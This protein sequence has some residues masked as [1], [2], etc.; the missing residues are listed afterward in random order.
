MTAP[1]EISL[2]PQAGPQEEA[3]STDADIAFIGGSVF[4]GKTWTL[5]FEATRHVDAP[6]FTFAI[7]RRTLPEITNPGGMWDE[8]V[9]MFPLF[10][11][12]SREHPPEFEFPSGAWGR[13]AGLEYNKSVRAWKGA[14]ICYLAIDQAEELTE[15]QFFY[16]LSRNRSTSGIRPYCRCSVNPDPDSWVR[17]FLA[18]WIDEEG[19]A[20]PARSGVVRW[21]IRVRDKIEWGDTREQLIE[22]YGEKAGKF[23]KSVTFILARL[24]D[25]VIGNEKDPDYESTMRALPLVEQTRLLGDDRGGNWNIREGAGL[26]FDRAKAKKID[27]LPSSDQIIA[28]ARGW[29]KAGTAGAGDLTAGI[30]LLQLTNGRFVVANVITGQWDADDRENVIET[31]AALDN[32]ETLIAVEQEP[33]SG[34]KESAE[35][36]VKELAGYDVMAIRSTTNLVARAN[37][38]ARQWQA[39]NVDVLEAE[40]TEMFL[41]RMHAFPTTGVPDDEVSAIALAFLRLTMPAG[42]FVGSAG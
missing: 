40:W 3:L 23:A 5:L 21:F 20:I 9:E 30:K 1:A 12:E 13:F 19:W 37:P 2:R 36:T 29:D 32:Y 16:M 35:S 10:G 38:F 31:T 22:K 34:G 14:Q 15:Y 4:G 6:G 18:W 41:R 17:K 27:V 24:Q 7:F 8:A 28:S 11:G 39:G 42:F 25:N 26:V 33:G